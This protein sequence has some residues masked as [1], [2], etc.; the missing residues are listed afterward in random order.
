MLLDY[1]SYF[2][3]S[4][5]S[6][7]KSARLRDLVADVIDRGWMTPRPALSRS[8][9][10][11]EQRALIEPLLPGGEDLS[12]SHA[13]SSSTSRTSARAIGRSDG[14]S[15]SDAPSLGERRQTRIARSTSG[16]VGWI[17]DRPSFQW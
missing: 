2:S 3:R 16:S 5:R 8:D 10:S 13:S 1:S 14:R 4:A 9:T 12:P 7:S 17:T 11:D 15:R 6:L